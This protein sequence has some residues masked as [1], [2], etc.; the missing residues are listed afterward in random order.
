M[1]VLW[2]VCFLATFAVVA[3]ASAS[4][5]WSPSAKEVD[6]AMEKARETLRAEAHSA[7]MR[8]DTGEA[9][10]AAGCPSAS[11]RHQHSRRATREAVELA[12]VARLFEETTKELLRSYSDSESWAEVERLEATDIN[13]TAL[14]GYCPLT[15][16]TCNLTRKYRE[17][18]G[19]CNNLQNPGWG[20]AASCMNRLLPAD[21]Q[22]GVSS[23]RVAADGS[24]LPNARE[25]SYTV[26]PN[27]SNPATNITHMVMQLGQFIDHDIALAPLM[28]D[29]GEIV[30]L[31]NPNNVVDC[32]SPGKRNAPNCFSI[33][34]PSDDPFFARFNQVCMNL[35]RSAPCTRCTLGQ[36]QQQDILTSYID[37][38]Q[39]YGSSAADTLRLRTMNHGLM[40]NQRDL[41]AGELLPR[42]FH[43]GEDRCSDPSKGQFCFRAGDERVNEH[44]GLTAMHT[45]FL[46]QHNRIARLLGLF[47]FRLGDEELFQRTKR[48]VECQFQHIVYSEWLPIVVGPQTMTRFGLAPRSSGSTTYNDSVDAT[49][50]NEFAAAAFRLGHTLIDGTFA[51]KYLLG[52]TTFELQDNYFFPFE[53]YDGFLEPVLRGLMQQRAQAFDR[54]VT[55][56]VTNHLY[57]LR[58]ESFGLDLVAL[59]LQR[60]R[61]HGVRPYVD[62]FYF[63]TGV[64]VTSFD[65]LKQYMDNDS[66]E[67]YKV[68]YKS[69]RDIDLFTA[70]ISEFSVPGGVV[71]P[72]L[73]CILGH[74]FQRLKYGDRFYY[75]HG[76]QAGSL[77]SAQL[78]QIRRI[79]FAKIICENT[80]VLAVTPNVFRP[81]G[82][83]NPQT[84]C[85]FLP[86]TDYALWA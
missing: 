60:A 9:G 32:C 86:D 85:F 6:A 59:N 23:P 49:M 35:P 66:V 47:N 61:E 25:I 79:S 46:R 51:A 2:R 57:R 45:V 14:S 31:G 68:L 80:G 22:D 78:D 27:A 65:T 21:Y 73:S 76:S 52:G 62:Y 16:V 11:V 77:T 38:S 19:K 1:E 56:G 41:F 53:F 50:L 84:S 5:S 33:D 71:G 29:P 36:R 42:S 58:N 83:G 15:N 17:A 13:S 37:T 20:S 10:R 67:K 55:D 7:R 72:T 26:H 75:E 24:P 74:M 43:A 70:G 34:I 4:G 40:K 39:I 64:N 54:D 69:V 30:N 44:P 3:T 48:I 18:D 12:Q 28:P 81:V 82:V 63:C 8:R